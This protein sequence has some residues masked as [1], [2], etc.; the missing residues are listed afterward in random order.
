MLGRMAVAEE[1]TGAPRRQ[2]EADT[3]VFIYLQGEKGRKEITVGWR[4]GLS[5]R[6]HMEGV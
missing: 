6:T 2:V 4:V 1:A 5:L 3:E